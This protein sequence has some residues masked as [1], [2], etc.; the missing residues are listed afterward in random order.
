M[1]N[2]SKNVSKRNKTN[3]AGNNRLLLLLIAVLLVVLFI[4][5][6]TFVSKLIQTDTYY[7][8]NK[9]ISAKTQIT[10]DILDPLETSEGSAPPNALSIDDLQGFNAYSQTALKAGDILSTS[11]VGGL[12]DISI[13]IPDSWVVTS[14]T[15]GDNDV[16]GTAITKG[17]YF[18]MMVI[19]ENGAYY[20]FINVLTLDNNISYTGATSEENQQETSS[21]GSQNYVV[22]MSPE[23]AAK[24]Q[25]IIKDS[26]QK[27]IKL[28][29]SP[30][31]NEY[32][33]PRIADYNG[34]F[35]YSQDSDSVIWPGN[36]E[37]IVNHEN[38]NGE[39]TN[40]NFIDI[41]GERLENGQPKNITTENGEKG[42]NH[43]E[44]KTEKKENNDNNDN[45]N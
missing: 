7:V 13:G 44:D 42:N 22:G 19:D 16:V 45:N 28:V 29:L 38:D 34:I 20:P 6:F 31:Q 26:S 2:K 43:S 18:D 4:V 27:T 10:E 8:L 23:N 11:N 25:S 15:I 14:F 3:S 32:A 30:R 39:V 12:E 37:K 9:D 35:K 21:G 40:Y 24:L 1:A 5:V 36:P 41:E 33:K 17:V